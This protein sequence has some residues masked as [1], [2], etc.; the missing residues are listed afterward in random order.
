[1]NDIFVRQCHELPMHIYGF[2]K[3]DSEGD[4]NI[5]INADICD[6]LKKETIR[7][8]LNHIKMNHFHRGIGIAEC[9][10]EADEE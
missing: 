9:E 10:V 8:E 4:Y 6:R 1:M 5:Y 7:H 2:V 3:L